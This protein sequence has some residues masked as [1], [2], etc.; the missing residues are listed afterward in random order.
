MISFITNF[1][2]K[3]VC[4]KLHIVGGFLGSGKTTAIYQ[5][6]KLL[7]SKGGKVGV[8]TNEQ[9]T[10]PEITGLVNANY[11]PSEEV[12]NGC[13][14]SNLD[15]LSDK[16]VSLNQDAHPDYIFAESVG[17]CTDLVK[18]VLKPLMIFNNDIFESL[19]LSIIVDA[20]MLLSYLK[21]E[22]LLF[23]D[24]V[25][26]IF[27][28]QIE[29]ADL[30]V[31][32]KIDLLA[33]E[34]FPVLKSLINKFLPDKII[35]TQSSFNPQNIENWMDTLD[36]LPSEKRKPVEIEY[37]SYA[38]GE[39]FLT[40]LDEEVTFS[41]SENEAGEAAVGF[42][43]ILTTEIKQKQIPIGHLKCLLV[44]G[45]QIQKIS[46]TAF[47]DEDWQRDLAPV[48]SNLVKLFII[49]RL[50]T[51]TDLL[52]GII[53]S[54]IISVSNNGVKVT[55]HSSLARP[56]GSSKPAHHNLE[57]FHCCEEC[58]CLKNIIARNTIRRQEGSAT[59]LAELEDEQFECLG[60]CSEGNGCCC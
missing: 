34:D 15:N 33:D 21:D 32:N 19:T 9:V 2:K 16:I 3:I 22:Q 27:E 14:S 30:L 40:W 48:S 59:A 47:D 13:F 58:T 11:S 53:Q 28:K 51:T 42:I 7:I 20:R 43:K 35:I 39:A 26:Y 29:E 8:I 5:A 17:S 52:Q 6:A 18:T 24:D 37:Q 25:T 56:S 4:M 23:G 55:T 54:S 1:E 46:I 50:E 12:I 31:L 49:A 38:R 41:T 60:V 10:Y 36:S 45:E 44:N 57:A